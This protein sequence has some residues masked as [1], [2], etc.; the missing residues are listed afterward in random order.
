ME[1]VLEIEMLGLRAVIG[2]SSGLIIFLQILNL[3]VCKTNCK[4]NL[5]V[6]KIDN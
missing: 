4:N 5:F 6:T 3:S 1:I 2:S